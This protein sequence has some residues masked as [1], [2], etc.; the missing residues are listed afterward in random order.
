MFHLLELS[1]I[2][3]VW[4]T[5][6]RD[7]ID[8]EIVESISAQIEQALYRLRLAKPTPGLWVGA[9]AATLTSTL[10]SLETELLALQQSLNW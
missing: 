5:T 1:P 7:Q 2:C 3:S 4:P 8:I 10:A 9:T 6:A